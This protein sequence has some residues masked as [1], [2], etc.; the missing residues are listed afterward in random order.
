M[1]GG[2]QWHIEHR[3]SILRQIDPNRLASLRGP[4]PQ[5][6]AVA[7]SM[8]ALSLTLAVLCGRAGLPVW[9]IVALAY[10]LGTWGVMARFV[11]LHELS[12]GLVLRSR[13][14]SR[15]LMRLLDLPC[16]H[17]GNYYYYRW[18]H[19]AHHRS[20]GRGSLV[21]ART[22]RRIDPEVLFHQDTF[23]LRRST[24]A[25]PTPPAGWSLHPWRNAARISLRHARTVLLMTLTLP[26]TLVLGA[27]RSS[28]PPALCW[29]LRIQSG[30]VLLQIAALWWLAGWPALLFLG[31]SQVLF[32]CPLHPYYAFF[33]TTH[34][35]HRS[36]QPTRSLYGRRWMN[37]YFLNINHHCEHHDFPEVPWLRLPA[38]HRHAADGYTRCHHRRGIIATI[39]AAL[40][41][42]PLYVGGP[43]QRRY[44]VG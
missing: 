4:A 37:L 6:L 35:A 14:A 29:D 25:D 23:R 41:E 26:A 19:L 9:A 7:L 40:V 21:E 36:G 2:A 16:L 28:Q 12:H 8:Q 13:R 33:A 38:L 27:V 5:T 30:L 31:L 17:I 32:Y 42:P 24:G 3:R 15:L 44:G 1:A 10:T 11:F 39:Q 43:E 18:G 34:D 20:L 22:L